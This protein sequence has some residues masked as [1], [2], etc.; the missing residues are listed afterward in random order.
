MTTQEYSYMYGEAI[1]A[2]QQLEAVGITVDLQVI[3]WATVLERRAK[4]E[5]WD[6]FGTGHGFVPDPSQISYVGQMNQ[7]PGWWS[8]REQPRAGRASCWPSRTSRPACRSSSRSRTAHYTEIPAIK[9]GD[10][11]TVSFRSDKRRRLG[12]AVRARRQVLESLA[13]RVVSREVGGR[14]VQASEYGVLATCRGDSTHRD[15]V[16]PTPDS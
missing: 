15:A 10:S 16:T 3:D 11:S 6:M 1:V 12:P 14:E 4:P 5:E 9:I 7:Y 8:S 2:Q 13:E